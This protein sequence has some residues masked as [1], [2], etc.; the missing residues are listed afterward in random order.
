[1]IYGDALAA[2]WVNYSWSGTPNFT[3]TAQVYSGSRAIAFTS[4]R[5]WA[6]LYLHSDTG[7]TTTAG[8]VLHFA[9]RTTA[10]GQVYGVRVLSTNDVQIGQELFLVNQGG[11][12]PANTWQVYDIPLSAFG[13]AGQKIGGIA[14]QDEGGVVQ[15]L[16]FVDDIRLR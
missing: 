14:I 3:S 10:P 11:N 12:P 13:A 1:M 15:P 16:F 9:L 7:V 2:G 4:A 6:G 8:T 5:R